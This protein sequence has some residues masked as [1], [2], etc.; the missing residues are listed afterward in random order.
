MEATWHPQQQPQCCLTDAECC[1]PF[2]GAR[3]LSGPRRGG[4]GTHGRGMVASRPARPPPRA[5]PVPSHSSH[6]RDPLFPPRDVPRAAFGP[7]VPSRTFSGPRPACCQASLCS[8]NRPF[9]EADTPRALLHACAP[10]CRPCSPLRLTPGDGGALLVAPG[11]PRLGAAS[12]KCRPDAPVLSPAAGK[13]S[14]PAAVTVATGFTSS[15]DV[16]SFAKSTKKVTRRR[17]QVQGG[18]D[19]SRSPHRASLP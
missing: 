11:S 19:A 14:G 12:R 15:L 5:L 9:H 3:G 1:G 7:P 17:R 4:A 6:P 18:G 2:R 13:G 10:R 16:L 8:L